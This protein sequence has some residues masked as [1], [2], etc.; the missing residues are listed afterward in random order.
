MSQEKKIFLN[1]AGEFAVASELNRR[2][3]LASITYGA[4]KSADVFA[5]SPDFAKI[6]RIEVKATDKKKW[7]IG[8]RAIDLTGYRSGVM[9]VFVQFPSPPSSTFTSNEERGLHAPRFFILTAQELFEAWQ[10]EV[11][12]YYAKYLAKHN[13]AF[14]EERGVPNVTLAALAPFEGRWEKILTA[15]NGA[16]S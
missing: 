5:L 14:N 8:R 9:W 3:C 16:G 13:R 11:A 7:P 6:V 2:E 10:Q 12:P 15:V 4:A 1:L